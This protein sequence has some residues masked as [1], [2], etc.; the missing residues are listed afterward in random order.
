MI[1]RVSEKENRIFPDL[2][3][4]TVP[5]LLIHWKRRAYQTALDHLKTH[6][7]ACAHREASFVSLTLAKVPEDWQSEHKSC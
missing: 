5:P 4:I 2:V 7:Q 3:Q 1:G 6:L